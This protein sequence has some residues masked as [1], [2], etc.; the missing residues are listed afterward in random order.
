MIYKILF[1]LNLLDLKKHVKEMIENCDPDWSICQHPQQASLWLF[2]S[3]W[4]LIHLFHT[5]IVFAF[6]LSFQNESW[7]INKLNET[8]V[9]AIATNLLHFG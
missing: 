4:K 6:Q 2:L 1:S 3:T 5:Q 7:K 8:G 9:R